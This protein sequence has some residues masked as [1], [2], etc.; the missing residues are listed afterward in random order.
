MVVNEPYNVGRLFGA[1]S[2]HELPDW[3]AEFDCQRW[4]QFFLNYLL[5]PPAVSAVIPATTAPDHLVA[6]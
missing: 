5:A 4:G 3:A 1:A 2:G 6:D